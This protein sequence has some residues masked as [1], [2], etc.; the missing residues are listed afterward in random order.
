MDIIYL[1]H[2]SFKIKGKSASVVCDP[3]NP[4]MVGLKFGPV[5]ADIVTISHEHDDHNRQELIK[6]CKKVVNGP[7]EY[8]IMGISILGFPS[9]HDTQKGEER[10]K[11]T[12]FVYEVD[13]IRIAHL[14]DLGHELSESL[15]ED[16][17]DIDILI[18]PVGGEFTIG[19]VEATKI[20][21]VIEPSI[22]IPMHYQVPGLNP[23]S[24]AKLKNVEDFLKEVGLTVERLPKLSL[25]KEDIIEDMQKVVVLEKK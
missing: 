24:F 18:L 14:G 8:E 3:Y 21:Q 2:S 4:K 20:V 19:P 25:K 22:T 16:M 12:I 13:G 15:V 7:G 23:V 9:Y 6:N 17:G 1:G 11:N 5:E 10:G